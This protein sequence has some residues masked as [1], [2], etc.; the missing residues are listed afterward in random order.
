MLEVLRPF[1]VLLICLAGWINERDR[2]INEYL[3]AANRVLKEQLGTRRLRLSDDQRRRLAVFG[4]SLGRKVLAEWAS[5]VTPDTIMRWYRKL[6]AEKRDYSGR[7]RCL[8]ALDL[9]LLGGTPDPTL[10]SRGF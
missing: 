4:K 2:R 7:R 3:R 10:S 5:L 9:T 6:V 1:D 8:L